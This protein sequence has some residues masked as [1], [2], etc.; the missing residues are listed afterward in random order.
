MKLNL[1]YVSASVRKI[2]L[3]Y[4]SQPLQSY[5]NVWIF[6]VA[7]ISHVGF[8]N[9]DMNFSNIGNVQND[10]LRRHTQFHPIILFL[11]F[12]FSMASVGHL[13]F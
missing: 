10:T 8:L 5:D 4:N 3:Q 12:I 1:E 13:G 2:L 11:V 6:K 7:V 9:N